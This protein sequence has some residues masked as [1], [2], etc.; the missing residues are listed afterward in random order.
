MSLILKE[1]K[2]INNDSLFKSSPLHFINDLFTAL[3]NIPRQLINDEKH[4]E[5]VDQLVSILDENI[6]NYPYNLHVNQI[7]IWLKLLGNKILNYNNKYFSYG[8]II[9]FLVKIY[10]FSF[11]SSFLL[12]NIY[13]KS[14]VSFDFYTN[15]LDFLFALYIEEQ[16]QRLSDEFKI[17]N[18]FY[19]YNN[20]P[21][22]LNNIHFKT[23]YFSLIFS[24]RIMK[25]ENNKEDT[26]LF[27]LVNNSNKII[28]KIIVTQADNILK[29]CYSNAE[30]QTNIKINLNKDYL[31]CLGQEKKSYWKKL[32]LFINQKKKKKSGEEEFEHL[33]CSSIEIP[34]FDQILKLE[35]GETNFEGL[36]GD[37]LIINKK[38]RSKDICHLYNLKEDY[39]EIIS[40]INNIID[41]NRNKKK[42]INDKNDI[43][44]FRDLKYQCELKILTKEINDLLPQQHIIP[45]QPYGE[46]KYIN[47]NYSISINQKKMNI[48][49]YKTTYSINDF[50]YLHG[51]EYLI[52]QLHKIKSLSKSNEELNFN[53]YKTLFF[54]L[55][56]IKM[57]EDYI[58]S[59]NVEKK[60]R[61]EMKFYIFFLSFF[62]IL[63]TQKRKIELD[64]KI[65]EI[66]FEFSE[67]FK[68]KNCI[69][70][71]KINLTILFDNKLF[72]I[73]EKKDYNKL[74]DE[75]IW[76]MN[77]N[78]KENSL[79]LFYK[80]I[81]LDDLLLSKSKE[82][83]HKKYMKI[84]T[85]FLIVNSK[86][87]IQMLI[88]D[89]FLQ[90]FIGIKNPKK[91]YHYLKIIFYEINA[92]KGFYK[93]KSEF[94]NYLVTNNNRLDEY[95][96]KY[97]CY[98][99]IICFLLYNIIINGDQKGAIFSYTPFGFMKN[100]NYNFIRCIFIQCF[101]IDNNQIILKFIKS[102]L[103]YDN[104]FDL[105]QKI[106]GI[107]NLN[108]LSYIDFDYFIP[109]LDGIIKYYC[110]LHN[111]FL[112][113][114]NIYLL[115]VLKKGIKLI[116]DFLDKIIKIDDLKKNNS[117]NIIEMEGQNEINSFIQKLFECSCIKLLFI[118]Y[119]HIYRE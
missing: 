37:I 11:Q 63:S 80:T 8:K 94:I 76:H 30:W 69:L 33:T 29:I 23:N 43:S 114:K 110:F 91:Q 65:R 79:F 53:L 61:V 21:L 31:I 17:E 99:Q 56:Y 113:N 4:M 58:F 25:I 70:L 3:I 15:S 51:F 71:H 48:R 111:E 26:I 19:V 57:A 95:N 41:L 35:L 117:N 105:L 62:T 116:L 64:K 6:F 74:F 85:N 13:E 109:K 50:L 14:A 101:N 49:I 22:S 20:C 96:N 59:A 73:N 24:F 112:I 81:L 83:K 119:F 102:S 82:I 16:N 44:Y 46:L 9:S 36:F 93:E 40:S 104:E 38:I 66:L 98:V 86:V 28:L 72:A 108:I 42:Y 45:I 87:N 88:N 103:N 77:N 7:Q 115:K 67:M 2:I 54:V 92:L 27:N 118:L 10:K 68:K 107:D 55:E 18:G 39:G 75:M 12:K 52:F 32:H 60:N 90:Y 34:D 1:G 84:I 47:N 5:L 89:I 97:C 106:M 78:D 100:P